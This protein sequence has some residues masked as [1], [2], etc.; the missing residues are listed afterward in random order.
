[1][2]IFDIHDRFF[3]MLIPKNLKKTYQLALLILSRQF[4][5]EN[6]LQ[7]CYELLSL[8][9]NED[10]VICKFHSRLLFGSGV[11]DMDVQHE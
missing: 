3:V 5:I 8:L 4:F 11:A 9:T 6:I 10:G 2:E 7:D 1:M